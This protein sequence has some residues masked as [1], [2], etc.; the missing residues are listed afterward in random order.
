MTL[1]LNWVREVVEI[2][3]RGNIIKLSVAVHEL[4]CQQTLF[5]LSRNCKK[6]ENPVM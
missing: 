3:V 2:Q 5:A 4:S 1:K 6:S